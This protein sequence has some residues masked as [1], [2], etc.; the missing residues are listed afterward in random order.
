MAAW[1]MKPTL[2]SQKTNKRELDT[3]FI[4]GWEMIAH[5]ILSKF[6]PR[7]KIFIEEL[8]RMKDSDY[9]SSESI[10]NKFFP[11]RLRMRNA[12]PPKRKDKYGNFM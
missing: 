1:T 12:Q 9:Y 2:T 7:H 4:E 5:T 6:T 11:H 8:N 3:L 10:F